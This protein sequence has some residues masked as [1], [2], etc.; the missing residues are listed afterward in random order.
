MKKNK[1]IINNRDLEPLIEKFEDRYNSFTPYGKAILIKDLKTLKGVV[2][3]L[4][5]NYYYLLDNWFKVVVL[6]YHKDHIYNEDMHKEV[7]VLYKED[8]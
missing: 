6:S 2:N 4:K 5:K 1:T 7:L 8:M 3:R